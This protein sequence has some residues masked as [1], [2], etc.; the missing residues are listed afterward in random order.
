[1]HDRLA[2]YFLLG[3]AIS[4][5]CLGGETPALGAPHTYKELANRKLTAYVV[6]PDDGTKGEKRPALVFFHGGGWTKG[7]PGLF[8]A[9][10]KYFSDRGLV[11]VLVE[12]RLLTND[13]T[14][15]PDVCLRDG[16][17]AMRW[18][19]THAAEIG[20]D[21][22]RIAAI[23]GSVGGN[24]AAYTALGASFD[25]ELDDK[26]VSPKP[27]ALIL[28]DP[29]LNNGP[30]DYGYKRVKSQY[31]EYSPAHQEM[32]GAPPTLI[33]GGAEDKVAK[34]STLSEYQAKMKSAGAQCEVI[35]YP[36][37]QYGFYRKATYFKE[38]ILEMDRFLSSL[39]WLKPRTGAAPD[40][41]PL[42]DEAG[43]EQ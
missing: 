13:P 16:K 23:G 24:I 42:A 7:S 37:A 18:V 6:Q 38:T 8:N 25:D 36:G 43:D 3:A 41:K 19:R 1:M 35:F 30:G 10:A 20:V 34:P 14:D 40:I 33:L 31:Q 9:T 39:G 11:C 32:Q 5:S 27:Q 28:I 4:S 26:N 29:V 22:S 2:L 15:P 12:Y 21:P 17:S